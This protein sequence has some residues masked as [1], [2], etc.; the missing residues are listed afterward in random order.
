MNL[1]GLSLPT[2]ENDTLGGFIFTELGKVPEVGDKVE[3]SAGPNS[4]Y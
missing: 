1:V 3:A 2:D 4:K